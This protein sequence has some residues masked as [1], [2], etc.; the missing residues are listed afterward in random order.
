MSYTSTDHTGR[1]HLLTTQVATTHNKIHTP[2]AELFTRAR[3]LTTL[4]RL[5][6]KSEA[7]EYLLA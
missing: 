2:L 7:L 1:T 6:A 3:S 5:P 4:H